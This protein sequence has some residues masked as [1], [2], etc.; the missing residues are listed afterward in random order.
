MQRRM[1]AFDNYK[2]M[3]IIYTMYRVGEVSVHKA[4]W[5]WSTQPYSLGEE[6]RFIQ[7]QDQQALPHV[8]RE[9]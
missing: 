2:R 5:E 6:V 3:K 7:A 9:W 8:V 1:Y 4:C